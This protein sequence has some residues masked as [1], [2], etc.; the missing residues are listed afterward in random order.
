MNTKFITTK[1]IALITLFL[2]LS[3]TKVI[4]Q[5]PGVI[6]QPAIGNGKTVLDPNG[7]GYVS[8]T[9]AG[10]T[11][12]DQVQSEIPYS[13]LVFPMVEPNSDLSAGPSCSFTDFV[14]Q[15][16]ED[17]VQSYYDSA[18]KN[19]LFRMR[20]GKSSPNSKSYSI[21]ID[22]DGKF[23][24]TG[25]NADPQ[26]SS[27]NPGFEIEIVLATNF[28][29]FVYDVN[30]SNCTPVISYPD[31]VTNRNYQK[32]V[33][34]TTSCGDPDYF[35]DFFVNMDD[36]TTTFASRPTNPVTINSSTAVRMAMVDNMGA[37][38]STVCSPASASDIAGVDSSCGSLE[39]C[40]GTIID[41]YT[42]CPPGQV[43]LDRTTCPTITGSYTASS[44]AISGTSN[45]ASGTLINVSV[46]ASDGTTFLGS[47]TTTTSGINWTINVAALSPAVT[48][49]A[50]QIIRAT[51]KA[52]GKGESIDNCSSKTVGASCN[53]TALTGVSGN[54]KGVCGG[55]LTSGATLNVYKD[56]IL[57]LSTAVTTSVLQISGTSWSYKPNGSFSNCSSGAANMPTGYYQF[58]QVVGGCEGTKVDYDNG[59]GCSGAATT[60]VITGTIFAGTTSISGTSG[61]SASLEL[62]IAGVSSGTVTASAGGAWTFTSKVVTAGQS[63]YVIATETGKCTKTA[64][65][66]ITVIA[67]PIPTIS[68][69][70]CGSVTTVSGSV[71]T[72]SGTIQLYKIGTPDVAV[73][74]PVSI[75]SN[76]SWTVSGLSLVSGNQIYA[77]ITL[78]GGV[79]SNS[80]TTTIGNQTTNA[81]VIST[82][83]TEGDTSIS[84]TGTNGDFV[85]LYIDGYLSS[86]FTTVSASNTWTISGI[87][88]NDLYLN[89]TVYVT[90]TTSGLCEGNASTSKVVQCKSPTLQ[91]Y[92]GG[93]KNY[94]YGSAGSITLDSSESGVIYE[95][96]NGAGTSVG[97]SAVGT[98]SSITLSTNALTANL[99]NVYVKAYKILNTSCSIT[100]TVAINFDTQLPSPGITLTSTNV[101]V[102]QSVTTAAFA[103]TSPVN[104]PT[105]YSIAFSIAAK[106]QGF[107]DVSSAA[108]SSSP[109]NVT[110]PAAAAVGSYSAILTIIGGGACSST[111]PISITVYSNSSPPVISTQPASA[112]ICSGSATTLS[113]SVSGASSYQ[114]Q[115][116]SSFGGTY[117]NVV[118]G[119]GATSANYTTATLNSTTYY[120]VLV[121]NGSGTTTSNVAT[122]TV[123]SPTAQTISGTS[124]ICGIGNSATWTS[125]TSGG[126][127]SSATPAV[128]K[129]DALTGLVTAVSVGT[130]VITYSVTVGG[131]VNTANKTVTVY[132]SPTITGAITIAQG[133][134]T[135]FVGSATAAAS[136]P[137]VSN[138]IGIATVTSTGVVTGVSPGTATITYTNTNGCQA[139]KNIIITMPASDN[140]NDGISDSVDLDDDNDGILDT[141]EC[142]QSTTNVSLDG[143][144][145]LTGTGTASN[146]NA[147][148]YLLKTNAI[149]YLGVNYDAVIKIIN[150]QVPSGQLD[151][152]TASPLGTLQL[153]GAIPNENPYVTYS[154]SIVQSGS[155]TAGNPTGTPVSISKLWITIADLDGNGG[156]NNY[157]DVGGY[158]S[159]LNA[160]ALIV[161]SNLN[162]NGFISGGPSGYNSF[163][164]NV[165]PAPNVVETDLTYAYQALFGSYTTGQFVF[166]ITGTHTSTVSR[167]QVISLR[168]EYSCDNDGDGIPNQIDLDSDNDNCSDAN[169]YYNLTTADGGDGGVYGIGTPT[170][171][172][173]GQVTTAA[174]AGTYANAINAGSASTLNSSTPTD[175]STS[176][177]GNAAFTTT[178]TTP[179]SGT[180]QHQWQVSTN[181]G[182]TWT[183]LTNTGVYT[184][185]TT[186]TLNITGATAGMN[187]YKYRDVVTQSNFICGSVI[188]TIANLCIIP[189]VPTLSL[190]AATCSSAGT[191]TISN[192]SASNTY[193][194]NPATAG[195]TVDSSGLISGMTLGTS[196]TV[197]SG[198]GTCTSAAS[199]SFSNAAML[200]TPSAPIASAQTFCSV[201]GKKV[202]DLLATGTSIKWYDAATAGTLYA[203]TETLVSGTYY[204]SQTVN[205]CE[206]SRTS[207]SVT[208]TPTPSA[209]TA[210]A[211]TFC[212]V[213]GKKVSDLLATGTSIKWYDAATA[214][215][216]YAGTE[217]LVSGTYYASQ[218]VNG[219]ESS[220][221]SVSVTVTPTPSA[222][223]AS[224]QTFCS[225]EGKK[226]SDLLATGTSIKWYDA[227][228]AGTLYAGTETLA[229]GTY[230][231][232][233][234]VNGCE[235]SRTSVSV[236][237]TPT[238]SAPTASAQTFCS[239]EGKKVS[240]LL[241]TGTSIKWYDAATAGTLYAGTETLVSGTYYASQ[242]VNGCESSRTSVSVTVTPTPSAPIASAQTFCSVEGKKVSDLLATGTSIKWYDA[243]TAGT[244]YAGTETLATGTYYASQ[245]VNGC[246]SSR[247]SVSV[248]VTPTPSAPTASAQT[249]CS[250]EGKKVSDLLATG[251]SIKWYDAATAGTLYAGT[252][253]LA[254]GTYYASQ[255]VN[256]CESTR[257]SV[258]V[259]VTP[260]P[261]APIASAQ[262]FCS[263]EGKKVSDLLATG[264][265]IKW[266]DAATAGTLYAGTE[267][268]ATGTYYASQTVNGCESSRTSVSVT[269]TPTPSAPTASAQTFCSVEGKKVSDLLATGTSIKWYDAATC[270]VHYMQEQKRWQQGCIMRAKR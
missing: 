46:Y 115:S 132:A 110:V 84:G 47:G 126:T 270:T 28:G 57:I 190:T 225:V 25:P 187:G 26:Y 139:T 5:T 62:F 45:E 141:D 104:S 42:P 92:L 43:C 238:P 18:T 154:L 113:V 207:V 147:N 91:N 103:Y 175:Q 145:F 66:S 130:S 208:V 214:G 199:A 131:C 142:S 56:G 109:I 90:A 261:S 217:T 63:V 82:S 269:V 181:N 249:F 49:A 258:S 48:L 262:T 102:L 122:V 99:T 155:A 129:V 19:W 111:Y 235:S 218:T 201:E 33:A 215:T 266:Y 38:K 233:Q 171:N 29:V 263:V 86:Y 65:S 123:N 116:A 170:V 77:K 114:W 37:Q 3:F 158:S 16:D 248:T 173:N 20:M 268:L 125:T 236:T 97:P 192:Y 163:R 136:N 196:Y 256:G 69:T 112:S 88:V 211:Q 241:A 67:A 166:G 12:D 174:Y 95:L 243:A 210:S 54:S 8:A 40:L 11:T 222:P 78:N 200:A 68:G 216:L 150:K 53:T 176:I 205:G 107:V 213:E 240:D 227:A 72:T 212:S 221:T 22:T 119:S 79:T 134:S 71:A 195:I 137:W 237:V 96:V 73:G 172:G 167:K 234:T 105:N 44:T 98:G 160:E 59:T 101:P 159:S 161:G 144:T 39:N 143:L 4:G 51:A 87:S 94:C 264:T 223:T 229:T 81:V 52:S 197:T 124:P 257:T 178:V 193:T 186:A 177:G 75:S 244:L 76:G 162:N 64:S 185:T 70:Y 203:G 31:T 152:T 232:S 253:T 198:N 30:N 226:V 246:E 194:F 85:Q 55:G 21:L 127:W 251:T 184:T 118:G 34:L 138:N 13:S 80:A 252:E 206:S 168:S 179:G 146:I 41:N 117:A 14:D 17:P 259:T 209:P 83:I 36:L 228:T 23:G 164:P 1:N 180:T 254:T 204:A 220:R 156:T 133:A 2:V 151:I 149:N 224:A 27:S 265:S 250:V 157:G 135:T 191:S 165:I 9:T 10:F 230:Y 247:T 202:S 93:S 35:Y 219:C 100:S 183:N 182:A 231:A 108:L 74:S 148:D 245:T 6:F 239:V 188:S 260:T 89:A 60:P 106:N 242:T 121:S 169:E 61:N 15:G 50:G 140:D 58:S 120:R 32:S 7:D 128:A 153:S 267:T 189:V 255:T 24:S